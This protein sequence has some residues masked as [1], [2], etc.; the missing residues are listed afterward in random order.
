MSRTEAACER[1]RVL[2]HTLSLLLPPVVQD[3]TKTAAVDL[4]D[5]PDSGA[6]GTEALA[7]VHEHASPPSS[8]SRDRAREGAE[9]PRPEQ[10]Q[11]L[12]LHAE[13]EGSRSG[14]VSSLVAAPDPSA[15]TA[16]QPKEVTFRECRS[17]ALFPATSPLHVQP[18][19]ADLA[20]SDLRSPLFASSRL[21][22]SLFLRSKLVIKACRGNIP[23]PRKRT[24]TTW[25]AETPSSLPFSFTL[26]FRHCL[27][28]HAPTLFLVFPRPDS[29]E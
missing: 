15:P 24:K 21:L 6:G 17:C 11:K 19:P 29:G 16:L 20:R 12:D 2:T 22:S 28:A 9:L 13:E 8:V 7:T 14:V 18:T 4:V 10:D 1:C 26:P 3:F 25:R 27:L 5:V 23:C